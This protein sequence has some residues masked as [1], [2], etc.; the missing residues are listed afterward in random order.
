MRRIAWCAPLVALLAFLPWPTVAQE[1]PLRFLG[2]LDLPD[3]SIQIDGT[4]VGGLSGIAYDA[5][6]G[7]YYIISD[8]RGDFGPARFYT[9]RITIGL[10]GVRN[11]QFLSV[12]RLDSD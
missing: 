7:V 11:V 2:E 9:A 1:Q 10:D 8:D 3:Q 6:R 5:R 12:T 4:T